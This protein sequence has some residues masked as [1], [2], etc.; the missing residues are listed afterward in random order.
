VTSQLLG[1][2]GWQTQRTVRAPQ[3]TAYG[4]WALVPELTGTV[5]EGS[6]STVFAA[7][8]SLI[9]EGDLTPLAGQATT[10]VNGLTVTVRWADGTRTVVDFGD[11]ELTLPTVTEVPA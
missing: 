10:E 6:D 7:L 5:G 1:L 9:G 2:H 11:G 4:P 8:A 3:G